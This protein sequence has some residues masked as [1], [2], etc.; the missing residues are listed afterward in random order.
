MKDF[1]TELKMTPSDN[2]IG[3]KSRV[4]T[5]GS[6]FA[7]AIGARL[8]TFKLKALV[9]PF[10]VIYNPASIHKALSYGIFN[11]PVPDHTF[12]QNH[13]VFLNYNFHS[14]FSALQPQDLSAKLTNTI[15]AVHYF[16]K[17]ADW[18]VLTYGTAW[19]YHR[20]DTGEIVANCHKLPGDKFT[21]SLLATEDVVSSFGEL[22]AQLKNLNPGIRVMLTVSPVRHLKDTHEL[23]QVSKSVLRLACHYIATQ[24]DDAEYFPAYELMMDDLR[25]YRFYKADMLHPTAEAEDYIWEKFAERYFS[26]ELKDFVEK[27]SSVLAAIRHK[28]FHPTAIGHQLFLRETLKRLAEWKDVVDVEEEMKLVRRQ[29]VE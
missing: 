6:C 10:G 26:V 1:R 7:D 25:D 16:L 29:I 21:R 28:P 19:V 2:P 17:D 11:E 3:L 13:E 14:T 24:F 15:G 27:W 22:Y 8:T 23:N 20:K 9:N 12:L 4:I 18:L 5:Q